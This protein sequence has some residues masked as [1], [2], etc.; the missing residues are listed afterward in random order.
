MVYL[1]PVGLGVQKDSDFRPKQEQSLL[2]VA[3]VRQ[4]SHTFICTLN[5][6][7]SFL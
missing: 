6:P 4:I 2:E 7:H 5:F 3:S 1:L